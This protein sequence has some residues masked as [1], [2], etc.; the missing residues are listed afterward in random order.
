MCA[1]NTA[2]AEIVEEQPM[3]IKAKISEIVDKIKKNPELMDNFKKDP[4]ATIEKIAGVDL[5]DGI[6]D[7]VVSGVKTALAGD[8]L[9]GAASALKKLF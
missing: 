3:D 4:E 8:K 2:V 1:K 5:P 9:S 7:K 6:A